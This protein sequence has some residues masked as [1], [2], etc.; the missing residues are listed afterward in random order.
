MS[1]RKK[2]K[3][4]EPLFNKAQRI[5]YKAIE[6]DAKELMRKHVFINTYCSA[7]G[8]MNIWVT[9]QPFDPN[10]EPIGGY[11]HAPSD[12]S[13]LIEHD[14][15]AYSD[16]VLLKKLKKDW[17]RHFDATIEW[18]SVFGLPTVKMTR[19]ENGEIK[20]LYDW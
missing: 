17:I 1:L 3:S 12:L 9:L 16:K 5:L 2:I 6:D 8:S 4:I 18:D 20:V 14:L 11:I 10:A 7:V 15:V 13:D 19:A